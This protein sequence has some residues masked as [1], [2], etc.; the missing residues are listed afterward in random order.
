MDGDFVYSSRSSHLTPERIHT[1]KK[2]VIVAV[3]LLVISG[4]GCT[5][6]TPTPEF[7]VEEQAKIDNFLRWYEE[8]GGDVKRE[9]DKEGLTLL[10]RAAWH[11]YMTPEGWDIVIVKFLV[12]TGAEVNA[13]DKNGRTPLHWA[14]LQKNIEIIQYL[15]SKGANVNEKNNDNETPLDIAMKE[16]GDMVI[17]QYLQEEAEIITEKL[18]REQVARYRESQERVMQETYTAK[19]ERETTMTSNLI[20][21]IQ[22]RAEIEELLEQMW[23][24]YKITGDPALRAELEKYRNDG[25]VVNGTP[26]RLLLGD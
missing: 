9:D 26:L 6:P 15:V 25:Y 12:S 20:L 8:Y 5:T 24:K 2:A 4:I 11:S 23:N 3:I 17:V 7:T 14:T 21:T 13:K 10:H 18:R 22:Q 1:M 19:R 16:H